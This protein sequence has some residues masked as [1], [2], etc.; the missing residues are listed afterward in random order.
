MSEWIKCD[1]RLPEV[2]E[3]ILAASGRA[4][5]PA[6]YLEDGKF[7][8]DDA[9]TLIVSPVTHWQPLPQAPNE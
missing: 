4:V 9:D 5:I 6:V 3:L 2:D 7:Y 8:L 1:E